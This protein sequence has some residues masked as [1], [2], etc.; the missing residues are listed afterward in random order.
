MLQTILAK[1]FDHHSDRRSQSPKVSRLGFRTLLSPH[2]HGGRRLCP[3]CSRLPSFWRAEGATRTRG[4][5]SGTPG[6]GKPQGTAQL[7]AVTVASA[8]PTPAAVASPSRC[9]VGRGIDVPSFTHRCRYRGL[10]PLHLRIPFQGSISQSRPQGFDVQ[11]DLRVPPRAADDP[12][13]E[14]ALVAHYADVLGGGGGGGGGGG[15]PPPPPPL[16]ARPTFRQTTAWSSSSRRSSR[17]CGSACPTA[18]SRGCARSSSTCG[19]TRHLTAGHAATAVVTRKPDGSWRI[20]CYYQGLNAITR[21]G[22]AGGLDALLGGTRGSRFFTKACPG[23][24][25]QAAI[26]AYNQLRVRAARR[27]PVTRTLLL[28]TLTT[29]MAATAG[30]ALARSPGLGTRLAN[31]PGLNLND[32]IGIPARPA[33][34]D[35]RAESRLLG[36][37]I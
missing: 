12:S 3:W 6:H 19:W 32:R 5:A 11:Q 10:R 34:P 25:L 1:V 36:Y 29:F 17:R 13:F 24:I 14:G 37:V 22:R 8:T 9:T 35:S 2:W 26:S 27:G 16:S 7:A 30:L 4:A 18:G 33:E 21:P 23:S 28:A 20:C 15:P 31:R